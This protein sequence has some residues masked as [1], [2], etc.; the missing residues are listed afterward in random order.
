MSTRSGYYI[1]DQY[2][3]HFVTFTVVGWVD[4]FTRKHCKDIFIDALKYCQEHKGL[5]V[6]AYVIMSNHVHLVLRAEEGSI[7]L[8][9]IIR[10]LKKYTSKQLLKWVLKNP[11]E[12]RTGWME[13]VFKYYAKYNSNNKAY[14]VWKQDNHPKV[15][16]YPRF[17]N[18]KL[19]YIHNNPVVAGIVDEAEA[20]LYSSARNYL[21]RQDYVL[22][23][24]VIDFGIQEGFVMV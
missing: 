9:A 18:R 5:V 10:D 4:I 15:V 16:L 24:S 23:V 3:A 12:S 20:Y 11:K 22:E 8:S 2:A 21:G 19:N 13:V 17:T 6:H 14:Q 1:A 7:G